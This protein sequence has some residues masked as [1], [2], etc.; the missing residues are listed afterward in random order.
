MVSNSRFLSTSAIVRPTLLR[1]RLAVLLVSLPFQLV[2]NQFTCLHRQWDP[3]VEAYTGKVARAIARVS[4]PLLP[5]EAAEALQPIACPFILN[6]FMLVVG[7]AVPQLILLKMEWTGRN[8][9]TSRVGLRCR[10]QPAAIASIWGVALVL[11][12]ILGGAF[13]ISLIAAKLPIML[14]LDVTAPASELWS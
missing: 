4:V 12:A 8:A 11:P 14:G 9:F 10:K 2:S 13:A 6:W 5:R 1:Q 3:E 7:I